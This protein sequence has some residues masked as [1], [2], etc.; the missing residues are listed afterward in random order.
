MDL[1]TTNNMTGKNMRILPE[2]CNI[3]LK[4]ID[5]NYVTMPELVSTIGHPQISHSRACNYYESREFL[6]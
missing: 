3:F 4:N 6:V 2:G 5:C 1:T